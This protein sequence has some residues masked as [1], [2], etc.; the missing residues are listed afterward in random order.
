MERSKELFIK[1][2]EKKLQ[3]ENIEQLEYNNSSSFIKE[4]K[5]WEVKSIKD[6][7]IYN[8][9]AYSYEEALEQLSMIESF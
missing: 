9:W 5:R 2:R 7:C 1:E 6:D 3:Q 8:I 4:K